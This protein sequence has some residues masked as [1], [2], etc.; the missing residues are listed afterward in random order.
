MST[1]KKAFITGQDGSYLIE[2][3]LYKGY[4][5]HG[6]VRRSS[7]FNRDRIDHLYQDPHIPET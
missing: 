3:F 1:R 6:L 5:T 2:F 4:E 7:I